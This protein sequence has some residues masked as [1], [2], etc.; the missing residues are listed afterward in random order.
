MKRVL[1]AVLN[2]GLGHASRSIPVI[3]ALVEMGC[4][5]VIASDGA[6]G[7]L[8]IQ[9]FPELTYTELPSYDIRQPVQANYLH[10]L[11]QFVK[12]RKAVGAERKEVREIISRF[13]IQYII[14]DNR[15][16]V[17]YEKIPSFIITHQL[18]LVTPWPTNIIPNHII[19]GWIG[20]F[21]ACWIPD[22][23]PPHAI[24]HHLHANLDIETPVQ[25]MGLQSR[26]YHDQLSCSYDFA[27]IISGPEPGRTFFEKALRR[28]LTSIPLRQVWV[29]GRP[30]ENAIPS[31]GA[32]WHGYQPATG[33]NRIF[34]QTKIVIARAGYSTIMDCLK[35]KKKAI[36]VITSGQPEQQYLGSTLQ[37]HEGFRIISE[38]QI[39][40]LPDLISELME[41][42]VQFPDFPA[43]DLLSF[44]RRSL[45]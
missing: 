8:L 1:V 14:S 37:K 9:E 2:W 39:A 31:E 33:I 34:N 5:V 12:I 36:L 32:E 30:M 25:Y 15:Y 16:G 7:E 23:S 43:T 13:N 19:K 18:R 20:K 38:N 22:H 28:T 41:T 35:L 24:A 40:T 4:E 26:L 10:W 6:A 27:V 21:N 29:L 44:L 11:F 17:Y 3:D 42:Q 45:R